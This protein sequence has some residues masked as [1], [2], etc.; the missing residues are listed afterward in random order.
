LLPSLSLARSSLVFILCGIVLVGSL[1]LGGSTRH[2]YLS[3]AVL[4][5]LAI[6]LLSIALWNLT[7][8]KW[9]KEARLA[10]LLCAAIAALPLLQLIPLPPSVWAALP[11]R[12]V[13]ASSFESFGRALPWLSISVASEATWLSALSLIPAIAVFLGLLVLGYA[14]RRM[15]VLLVLAVGVVSV[16]IGLLQVAQGPQSG[17]RF[18]DVTNPAEAVGFFANR[19]H[20][21]ALIYALTLFTAALAADSAFGAAAGKD[22]RHYDSILII[23]VFAFFI[24][25]VLLLSGQAMARSRTG[26]ALTILG[27]FGACALGLSDRRV[28]SGFTSGKLLIGASALA[29]VFAVQFALFRV[30]ERFSA[31]P[32]ENARWTFVRNTIDA[33]RDYMPFGSGIGTFVPVYGLYEKPSEAI[34]EKYVNHAHNDF[35][36]LLL[37]AGVPGLIL[38]ILFILWFAFRSRTLWR[39]APPA[40]VEEVDWSLAR[41]ASIVIV[42]IMAHSLLDYPLR[43]GAIMAIFA[44]ASALLVPP[45]PGM[46]VEARPARVSPAKSERSRAGP[47]TEPSAIPS[48]PFATASPKAWGQR[49]GGPLAPSSPPITPAAPQSTTPTPNKPQRSSSTVGESA[50][51]NTPRLAKRWGADLEWPEEW[52][53]PS[54]RGDKPNPT[55]PKE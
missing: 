48:N 45:P 41:A 11:G 36:E 50:P 40:G 10:V 44:L 37:E 25:L 43:T 52:K 9:S 1:L 24:I 22:W 28:I 23:A 13:V 4:Q 8:L 21:A 15:L 30:L 17:L 16:F 20:F 53:K 7:E 19:N 35:A 34:A 51:E 12:E 18:F 47:T 49:Q 55:K 26:L 5:L 39:S 33:A 32:L 2:G 46:V 27:I 29:L 38:L 42:L 54:E 6:P 14:E 31:D 3:D